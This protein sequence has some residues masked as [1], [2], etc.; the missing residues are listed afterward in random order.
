MAHQRWQKILVYFLFSICTFE[1]AIQMWDMVRQFAQN[2]GNEEIF[3]TLTFSGTLLPVTTGIVSCV[4]QV[5]YAYQIHVVSGSSLLRGLVVFLSAIQMLSS[6]VQSIRSFHFR[7]YDSIREKT[8]VEFIA[9]LIGS[10]VCDVIIAVVMTFY[11]FRA[12]SGFK[13]THAPLRKLSVLIIETGSASAVLASTGCI[14]FL[15][16]S[17]YYLHHVFMKCLMNLYFNTLLVILN[18]RIRIVGGREEARL[19]SQSIHVN[20][21]P[22]EPS[23]NLRHKE[24]LTGSASISLTEAPP[25]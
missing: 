3:S 25:V 19:N 17:D 15:T 7:D 21:V 9:W 5:F 8:F 6:I 23:G 1:T 22:V 2:F 18:N 4:V 24:N 12:N 14:V 11:L 20:H 10:A 13:H 16:T